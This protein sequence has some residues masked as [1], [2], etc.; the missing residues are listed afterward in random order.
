MYPHEQHLSVSPSS[1]SQLQESQAL[2]EQNDIVQRVGDSVDDHYQHNHHHHHHGQ[3]R[4]S[5]DGPVAFEGDSIYAVDNYG[6]V[7]GSDQLTLSFRGQVYV[8]DSVTPDKVYY[9][10]VCF[11]I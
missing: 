8:F 11:S 2:I 10:Y 5:D 1:P 9:N 6:R 4:C 7:E 3:H